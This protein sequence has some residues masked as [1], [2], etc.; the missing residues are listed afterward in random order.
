MGTPALKINTDYAVFLCLTA[1]ATSFSVAAATTHLWVGPGGTWCVDLYGVH[2]PCFNG[3]DYFCLPSQCSARVAWWCSAL[4]T[5]I[6]AAEVF[7]LTASIG[8][9]LLTAYTVLGLAMHWAVTKLIAAMVG[10]GL[11]V[12]VIVYVALVASAVGPRTGPCSP[13]LSGQN[14]GLGP[15]LPCAAVGAAAFVVGSV[16][17]L[18]IRGDSWRWAAPKP[19]PQRDQTA[20]TE[21]PSPP[22]SL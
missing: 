18:V 3:Q 1:T 17:M 11:A 6:V 21:E 19:P 13:P 5:R 14:A 12:V 2:L 22:A 16:A 10:L 7:I 9:G 4:T 20:E 15:S 8:G